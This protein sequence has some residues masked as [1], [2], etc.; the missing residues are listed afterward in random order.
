MLTSLQTTLS[1]EAYRARG[2]FF[3]SV[4]EDQTLNKAVS[5]VPSMKSVTSSFLIEGKNLEEFN[6]NKQKRTEVIFLRP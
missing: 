1:A 6:L 4:L 5:G 3:L 2:E